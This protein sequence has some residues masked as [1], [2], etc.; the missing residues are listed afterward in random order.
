MKSEIVRNLDH[1]P[2][3]NTAFFNSL[4][5][6]YKMGYEVR[7]EKEKEADRSKYYDEAYHVGKP[8]HKLTK[9]ELSTIH[10]QIDLKMKQLEES[11][12]SKEEILYNSTDKG[13]PL[14]QDQFFQFLKNNRKAREMLIQASQ[15]FSVN[16][17]IEI[18]LKQNIGPDPSSSAPQQFFKNRENF[19]YDYQKSRENV[20]FTKNYREEFLD[21]SNYYYKNNL[22]YKNHVYLNYLSKFVLF[23]N[24]LH[25]IQ[26]QNL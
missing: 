15:E 10:D 11:G 22:D 9:E 5:N 8:K 7:T 19:D 4:L 16:H 21:E 20:R 14:R 17:V 13:L 26:T 23:F 25:T 3:R 2:T 1:Y 6:R 12:Q 24:F 18:A